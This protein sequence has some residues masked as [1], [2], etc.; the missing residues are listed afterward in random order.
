MMRPVVPI[1]AEQKIPWFRRRDTLKAA[2]AWLAMGGLPTAMAQKRSNLVQLIGDVQLNGQRLLPD[3]TV[4]TGDYLQ[5]GPASS[6]IFVIGDSA[7]HVRANSR[8]SLE[9]GKSL[10]TVSQL[11]LHSG[12]VASVWATS[13][14]H[15]ILMPGLAATFQSAGVY[16]QASD[17]P[18]RASYLCNCY[19]TL[20]LSSGRDKTFCTSA[21][22]QAFWAT[23]DSSEGDALMPAD[24][25][26]HTDAELEFLAGL[27][28][29]KTAWQ[30]TG[31]KR[32]VSRNFPD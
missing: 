3:Q 10:T 13:G 22:H 32:S 9:R 17:Q 29:R 20:A 31:E 28:N 2:A 7:F 15:Q 27:I 21:Y 12:A 16:A 26:N 4:Q 18:G 23:A 5:T 11:R 8:L 25:I 30:V 19:G 6:V 1:G 14:D 24:S